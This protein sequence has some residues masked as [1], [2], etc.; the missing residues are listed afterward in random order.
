MQKNSGQ[1]KVQFALCRK[2]W[3]QAKHALGF[4]F[5]LNH[6][7]GQLNVMVEVLILYIIQ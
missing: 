6:K 1:D 7:K 4:S 5:P 3:L 2:Y